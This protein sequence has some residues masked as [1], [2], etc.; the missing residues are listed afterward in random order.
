VDHLVWPSNR[1]YLAIPIII[2]QQLFSSFLIKRTLRIG[3]DQQTLYRLPVSSRHPCTRNPCNKRKGR[4]TKTCPTPY[5]LFQLFLSVST[6]I[7][8]AF[9][10]FGWKIRVIIVPI[11]LAWW[12]HQG[13]ADEDTHLGGRFGYSGPNSNRTRKYPPS[14]GVPAVPVSLLPVAPFSLRP[15]HRRS[16]GDPMSCDIAPTPKASNGQITYMALEPILP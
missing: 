13:R 5:F 14:Y 1:T 10:T 4:T 12:S 16:V 11:A 2:R 6:Q 9:D 7:S 8:P 15:Y 3:I